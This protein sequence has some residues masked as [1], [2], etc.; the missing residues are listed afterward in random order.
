MQASSSAPGRCVLQ[1]ARP[2]L[3]RCW[4]QR[5]SRRWGR[6]RLC[7]ERTLLYLDTPLEPQLHKPNR[8]YMPGRVMGDSPDI[9][10][11]LLGAPPASAGPRNISQACAKPAK[12]GF[13]VFG[14]LGRSHLKA[15]P[16]PTASQPI[17]N[18]KSPQCD[19][20]ATFMR[21]PSHLQANYKPT[22][23]HPQATLKP[24]PCDPHATFKPPSSHLHPLALVGAFVHRFHYCHA[25]GGFMRGDQGL[26]L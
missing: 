3:V 23:S 9:H 11:I 4:R 1:A 12:G 5:A 25:G 19:P 22:A 16:K 21:L 13:P 6:F 2:R 7:G 24:P 8:L 10:G 18:P 20:Q 15:T 14:H 26:V 17:G